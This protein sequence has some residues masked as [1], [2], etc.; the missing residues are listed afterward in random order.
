MPLS[1]SETPQITTVPILSVGAIFTHT[2]LIEGDGAQQVL[3]FQYDWLTDTA[4]GT[5]LPVINFFDENTV[6]VF[7]SF[8]INETILT[9]TLFLN[10]HLKGISVF[11]VSIVGLN[12]SLPIDGLF[13]FNDW[14]FTIT[15]FNGTSAGDTFT[16]SFQVKDF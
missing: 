2:F 5:R 12:R 7:R 14:S 1:D 4:T 9:L 16:G 3:W 8:S 13:A 15:D 11:P 10:T 6:N